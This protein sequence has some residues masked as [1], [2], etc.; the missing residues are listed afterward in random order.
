MEMQYSFTLPSD[1]VGLFIGAKHAQRLRREQEYGISIELVGDQGQGATGFLAEGPEAGLRQLH[2][3]VEQILARQNGQGAA[4]GPQGHGGLG[5]QRGTRKKLCWM[6]MDAEKNI[7]VLLRYHS[8]WNTWS[9]PSAVVQDDNGLLLDAANDE[10]APLDQVKIVGTLSLEPT[11]VVALLPLE[12]FPAD[13]TPSCS[14]RG[15][16]PEYAIGDLK[17][18]ANTNQAWVPIQHLVL[19]NPFPKLTQFFQANEVE[20]R[21]AWAIYPEPVD[22]F[23]PTVNQLQELYSLLEKTWSASH[24]DDGSLNADTFQSIITTIFTS[25]DI[26]NVV[27]RWTE[28]KYPQ[29]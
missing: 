29:L 22:P 23:A 7:Y 19:D 16:V 27:R 11:T 26:A 6:K 17:L 4:R 3:D 28:A 12:G 21:A 15:D 10:G 14:L 24:A 2:N 1:L 25:T 20:L 9:F 8:R 13:F 18:P 5:A